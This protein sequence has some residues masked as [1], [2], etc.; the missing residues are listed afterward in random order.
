MLVQRWPGGAD[1]AEHDGRHG[2]VKV[3]RLIDD[4]RVVA[5][6]LQQALAQAR[7]DALADLAADLGGAGEG[8]QGD[9]AILH[10][11]RGELGAEV[12]EELEH[13]R[14]LVL[15]HHLVAQALHRE[16]RERGLRRGLPHAG[17][18]ADRAEE[19]VPRPHRHGEVEGGDDADHPERVPL[20]GHA[21][22]RALRVHGQAVEHA[23]LADGEVGDV[24]HLLHLAQALG[25]DLA[26]LERHQRAQV[27]LVGAQ[28]LAQQ[29]HGLAALGR[30]HLAPGGRRLRP[31]RP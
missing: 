14:Q 23:R 24:D 22:L 2:Q 12:D 20:L 3:R 17:V 4:D 5:T 6:E 25:E 15:G 29:P 1:G 7:G 31:P 30:G 8:D 13:R 16:R 11:A 26:V 28:C 10:E 19:G 9:A 27:V 21:V 18:A